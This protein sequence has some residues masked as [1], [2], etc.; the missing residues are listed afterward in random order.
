MTRTQLDTDAMERPPCPS[1]LGRMAQHYGEMHDRAD[2]YHRARSRA[3]FITALLW[4]VMAGLVLGW[5]AAQAI[6]Q[7]VHVDMQ[8]WMM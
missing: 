2:G 8:E 5:I 4:A 3:A 1:D 6:A 7:A